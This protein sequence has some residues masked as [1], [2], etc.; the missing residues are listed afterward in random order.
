MRPFPVPAPG[1]CKPRSPPRPRRRK[2][3]LAWGAGHLAGFTLIRALLLVLIK[4]LLQSS[5]HP[6]LGSSPGEPEG[7]FGV[8]NPGGV[9]V[10]PQ[11][12][13]GFL[14]KQ[15]H[16]SSLKAFS[17]PGGPAALWA[18]PGTPRRPE[19]SPLRRRGLQLHSRDFRTGKREID[20]ARVPGCE[21]GA[22]V[23]KAGRSS[24]SF[25]Q[26]Y[27]PFMASHHS[28]CEQEEGKKT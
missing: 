5:P 9:R 17:P 25:K 10:Q 15:P 21:P 3:L 22:G 14:P 24:H 2:L 19:E 12:T 8:T 6:L 13:E 11:G 4:E 28:P 20:G 18:A 7:L 23:Y 16:L 1:R 27:R 26:P